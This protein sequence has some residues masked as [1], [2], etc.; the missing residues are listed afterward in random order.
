MNSDSPIR[1]NQSPRNTPNDSPNQDNDQ[2]AQS[3]MMKLRSYTKKSRVVD[4][5]SEHPPEYE[6]LQEA[7][8]VS[9]ELEETQEK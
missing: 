8:K 4:D 7:L 1:E 3:T 9:K 6:E 5:S 2:D